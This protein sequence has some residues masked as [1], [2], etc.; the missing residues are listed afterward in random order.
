MGRQREPAMRTATH[1]AAEEKLERFGLTEVDVERLVESLG[2][3]DVH[4]RRV[5]RGALRELGDAAVPAL[6]MGS[7]SKNQM[8][9]EEAAELL[10][11]FRG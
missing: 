6:T 11:R 2:E 9:R 3:Q 7:R 5:V 1:L 10:K 4:A 8:L